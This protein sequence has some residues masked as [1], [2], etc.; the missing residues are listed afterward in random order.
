[1]GFITINR[2]ITTRLTTFAAHHDESTITLYDV[3]ALEVS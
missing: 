3:T 1:M 2:P